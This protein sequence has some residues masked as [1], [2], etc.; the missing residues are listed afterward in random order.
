MS[1]DKSDCGCRG[2]G[3]LLSD[4]LRRMGPT[5]NVSQHFRAARIE[6]LKGLRAV[7]DEQ[8]ESMAAQPKQGTKIHVE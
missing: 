6:V 5:E 7:L 1:Q 2:A 4:F 3:P 8:I